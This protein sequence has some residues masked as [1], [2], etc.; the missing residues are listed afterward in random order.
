M[1]MIQAIIRPERF[2]E[3]KDALEEKGHFPMTCVNVK[4]RGVQKGVTLEYR[5]KKVQVDTLPKLMIELV[6]KD[7]D[8]DGMIA[9]ISGRA[10]TGKKGDG[11][12]FVLPVDKV[13]RIRT[14]EEWM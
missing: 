2:E 12:I 8:L 6:G 1:K 4:G 14:G 13:I 9:T 10:R 5:G 11:T 7:E 3:V